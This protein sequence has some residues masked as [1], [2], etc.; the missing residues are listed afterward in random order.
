[1]K[2]TFFAVILVGIVAAALAQSNE[3][4]PPS[5]GQETAQATTA[6]MPTGISGKKVDEASKGMKFQSANAPL[7]P[8][9]LN[10]TFGGACYLQRPPGDRI[11][12]NSTYSACANS[13]KACGCT[14]S[15]AA[16]KS[17]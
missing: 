5:K 4:K 3:T 15:F 16:G 11:C 7:D 1:M 14:F 8:K 6:E 12:V 2:A 17:C 13:A 9:L 10:S